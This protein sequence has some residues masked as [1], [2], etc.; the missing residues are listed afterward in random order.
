MSL[1]RFVASV[2]V[3]IATLVSPSIVQAQDECNGGIAADVSP[4]GVGIRVDAFSSGNT[5]VFTVRNNGPCTDYTDLSTGGV[6]T[7]TDVVL[8]G[9]SSIW[10]GPWSQT[11]VTVRFGAGAPGTG[12]VY[13]SATGY[14][15]DQG[16]YVVT[17]TSNNTVAVTPDGQAQSVIGGVARTDTFHVTNGG[18]VPDTYTLVCWTTGSLTCGTV[19]PSSLTLDPGASAPIVASFVPGASGTNGTLWL[20]AGSAQASDSGSFIITNVAPPPA[21]T[22]DGQA[23]AA[24]ENAN[25]T[26][27]FTIHNSDAGTL[28]YTLTPTCTGTATSCGAPGSIDVAGGAS[29]T[30]MVSY[31]VGALGTTG[32][33]ALTAVQASY[34]A[35][36]DSGWVR[37]LAAP[38]GRPRVSLVPTSP[39]NLD[40]GLCLT[41][42]AGDAAGIS[43]GD[44]FVVHAMPTYRTLGRDRSLTL[45]YNSAAAT[46]LVLVAANV[47]EP[48][49]VAR[50]DKVKLVL[51][52]GTSKDSAEFVPPLTGEPQQ[53]VLGRGL[54][55]LWTWTQPVTLTVTNFYGTASYDTTVTGGVLTVNRTASEFGR[56][57]SLLGLEAVYFD[58]ADSTRLIWLAGDG[59]I[60]V[61]RKPGPA[62]DVYQGAPGDRPDSIV[63]FDTLGVKW[64]RRD[65]EH[66]AAV[67]FDETG[68]H[69]ATRNRVGA[70]TTFT[71]G[72]VAGKIRLR[73]ITVPPN[74]GTS[75]SYSFYYD[76]VT[77]RLDSIVDPY[78]RRLRARMNVDT[79]VQLTLATLVPGEDADTTIFEYVAGRMTQRLRES[80][81]APGG[82][83]GTVYQ[84]DK[85]ARVTLVK[86]PSGVTGS[87]TAR[88]TLAPWDEKGLAMGY[89][90][91]LGVVTTV[92]TGVATRVDGPL[93]GIGDATDFWVDRFGAPIKSVQLHLNATIRTWHD[94]VATLPALVTR[95]Q[96]PNDRIVRMSWNARGNLV[97]LRDSS[98]HVDSQA[99]KTTTYDYGDPATPD[100][101][102][103]VTDGL[104]RRTDYT[105]TG[106]GL[107]DSVID[108]RS[109]VTKFFYRATGALTGVVDSVAERQVPTWWQSDTTEHVQ[110]QVQRFGYDA[111]G[112]LASWKSA[113][114]VRS[115][116]QRNQA[117]FVTEAWDP[118]GYH[119]I[120]FYDGFNRVLGY[121]QSVTKATPPGA[122]PLADCD[123]TQVVCV[124][125]TA[126]F[127]PADSFRT[128]LVSSYVYNDDGMERA[129]DPRGVTRRFGFDARGHQAREWDSYDTDSTTR[130]TLYY[131]L[132]G[133]LDSTLS[134]TGIKVRYRYDGEGRRT[135][136]VLPTVDSWYEGAPEDSVFADS[137]SYSYDL[138]GNLGSAANRLGHITRT[139]YANGAIRSQVVKAL[140]AQDS[141]AY[142][143]DVTGARTKLIRRHATGQG[144]FV[145]SIAYAYGTTTGDLDSLL[146]W[147]AGLGKR[148]VSFLWDA[149]GRRRKI[150]YPVS[151]AT[152]TYRYDATGLVRAVT[153]QNPLLPP[154]TDRFDFSVRHDQ[155]DAAGRILHQRI[156]CP[157]WQGIG[158]A[159]GIA[160]GDRNLL[161]TTN[162][163]NRFGILVYQDQPQ[164]LTTDSLQFD[165]SG[166]M[167]RKWTKDHVWDYYLDTRPG[168]AVNNV[169]YHVYRDGSIWSTFAY[170]GELARERE[171]D[172]QGFDIVLY[173]YDALGRTAGIA[174]L[175]AST[176]GGPNNCLY[177]PDG[178]LAQPCDNGAPWLVFDGPAVG[179]GRDW[180]FV[181][182]AGVDDPLIGLDRAANHPPTEYAWVTDGAGRQFA[183]G[184]ADGTLHAPEAEQ[185]KYHG[186]TYAGGTANSYGFAA[187]RFGTV[188]VPLVS[189]FRNRVYDQA[190]GRWT[191]EDPMGV[192]GGLNLYQYAGNNPVAYT[193]PFGLKECPPFCTHEEWN[194]LKIPEG[195]L[196][197]EKPLQ[198][199]LID[200]VAILAG[201]LAGLG[202]GLL[203]GGAN[204]TA[205]AAATP[206]ASSGGQVGGQFIGNAISG[207]TRHGL[208]Q[209]INRGV[210]PRALLDAA[211]FGATRPVVVDF[212]GRE[213]IQ[214]TGDAAGFAINL[215]GKVVSA[216]TK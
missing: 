113:V 35:T 36:K 213:S 9:P 94:S 151:N 209:I 187:D 74:D 125:Q 86:I 119:R 173:W 27:A 65:L 33:V 87:D 110:D 77:A 154:S 56:G 15:Q 135:A 178:Q 14:Q 47:T 75:R 186:G 17:A 139:Y 122:P 85:N 4:D 105:Y 195:H 190:T 42:G 214:I 6:G 99:T 161:E 23:V 184:T 37:V 155:V 118:L 183:A 159:V 28:T 90:D 148:K 172:N 26:Q 115:T 49:S 55:P 142:E 128:D 58:P 19:T 50:P 64:Y 67:L 40:R 43:C 8:D 5:V 18:G 39:E 134:R 103:R 188:Q 182:G 83:V 146:V 34:T 91:Q 68:L 1:Q 150:T 72:A 69:R 166:N 168:I 16:S 176:L 54:A 145:D 88:I 108:S 11:A 31:H 116:Y 202:E 177:D 107:T 164:A 2:I 197:Q 144:V 104:G 66:T 126:P 185:Y 170:S 167:I 109:H 211:R 24:L 111:M 92:D 20:T 206:A 208:N 192:A 78:E 57:W 102:T 25:A 61:Y 51:T 89:S 71:W 76:S 198:H 95:V 194:R 175:R 129:I 124:D 165:R 169:L 207:F 174:N 130:R 156:T 189:F 160:C 162:R 123:E 132:A 137:V 98:W 29:S 38:P 32:S 153:S 97:G 204:A 127:V 136:M 140:T 205:S 45:Y 101:P 60:R 201:G 82:F 143:Y 48:D 216:W 3:M 138:M 96:Y 12:A 157:G 7:A 22:P 203:V 114:G 81:A 200:P 199:P 179:A 212:L 141:V 63:R 79:L 70:L 84:Y 46:G 13:L 152:V 121:H 53:M 80:S 73:A 181:Q 196:P 149:L 30:V 191:Q 52:V 163:Y 120:W 62:G 10:M 41:T 193:D 210:A 117:G 133:E 215:L 147:W 59:S 112:N 171:A 44:L 100:S 158:E 180:M 131:G 93:A 21:V 106:L